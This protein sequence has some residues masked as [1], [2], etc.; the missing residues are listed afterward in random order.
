MKIES[1][2]KLVCESFTEPAFLFSY[3]MENRIGIKTKGLFRLIGHNEKKGVK[4]TFTTLH[5]ISEA[6]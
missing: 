3:K 5:P 1:R 4:E 6:I 2:K